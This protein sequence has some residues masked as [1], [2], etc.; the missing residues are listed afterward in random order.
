MM[1]VVEMLSEISAE[2]EE[3]FG[4]GSERVAESRFALAAARAQ[5]GAYEDALGDL[6]VAARIWEENKDKESKLELI[7][8]AMSA[9]NHRKVGAQ[10]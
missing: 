8:L 1:D 10:L 2:C 6:Q 3:M 9:I 7:E 4:E 5:T